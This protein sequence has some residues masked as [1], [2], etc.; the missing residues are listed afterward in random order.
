M[1]REEFADA[2]GY[3]DIRLIDEYV[4]RRKRIQAQKK[5]RKQQ[6]RLQKWIIAACFATFGILTPVLLFLTA[7]R[8]GNDS[9]QELNSCALVLSVSL[10]ALAVTCLGV[11]L[12]LIGKACIVRQAEQDEEHKGD[13][14][15]DE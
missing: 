9:V 14:P 15:G 11:V 10:C 4:T 1:N 13:H 3:L 8:G 7:A 5:T 6:K 12:W 2:V